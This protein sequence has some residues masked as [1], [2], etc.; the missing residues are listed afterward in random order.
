MP[1][2]SQLRTDCSSSM[3][4]Q[5]TAVGCMLRFTTVKFSYPSMR[6]TLTNGYP[7]PTRSS[8]CTSAPGR[9][10]T[11]DAVV[12]LTGTATLPHERETDV[13]KCHLNG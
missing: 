11:V 4:C 9:S 2:M 12:R 1:S 8:A 3:P 13:P 6:A 10:S 7:Y 5:W